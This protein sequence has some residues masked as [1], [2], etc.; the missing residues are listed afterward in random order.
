MPSATEI[1][2]NKLRARFHKWCAKGPPLST[3]QNRSTIMA[4]LY[5]HYIQLCWGKQVEK[6]VKEGKEE[7]RERREEGKGEEKRERR[8]EGKGE[9]KGK[10]REEGKGEEKGKR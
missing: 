4:K 10:R 2:L 6:E 5:V 3:A 8:E 1:Q 9:E 7:E